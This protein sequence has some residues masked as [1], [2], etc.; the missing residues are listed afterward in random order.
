MAY[1]E[2]LIQLGRLTGVVPIFGILDDVRE[3]YGAEIDELVLK[4]G[5][6]VRRHTHIGE[7][8]DPDRIRTW[9]PPLA[10]SSDTWHFDRAFNRGEKVVLKPGELAIFHVDHPQYL[11]DYIRYL[12]QELV[13]D[14]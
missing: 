10:Q 9:D 1:M 13:D 2:T 3:K 7:N 4:Y 5:S 6:D 11:A 8:I 12:F 14:G